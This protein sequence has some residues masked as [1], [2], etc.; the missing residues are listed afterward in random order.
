[1]ERTSPGEE[2]GGAEA[3]TFV[4]NRRCESRVCGMASDEGLK[5]RKLGLERGQ[6]LS[7]GTGLRLLTVVEGLMA[8]STWLPDGRR[9]L[10]CLY[11][12]GDLI[13]PMAGVNAMP[14]Q[15]EALA[16][17]RVCE[18]DLDSR[19]AGDFESDP[20]RA[21]LKAELF[22]AVHRQIMCVSVHLVTLGRLDGMERVCL[23]LADIAWRIG[24]DTP[25]G[26]RFHL[27]LS[28][29][30]IAD[31]LGLNAE[32]VSRIF[33]RIKKSKLATFLSPTE[34]LIHDIAALEGRVP[35][36]APHA[37][38]ASEARFVMEALTCPA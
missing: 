29:E 18:I 38:D 33:S 19:G 28:R 3:W 5:P 17:S 34:L 8:L 2:R 9:Q 12:P 22:S 36:P 32:T 23:F 11:A 4:A 31:Y 35:V 6:S 24:R 25:G 10:L 37:P 1:M 16:P 21:A 26:R 14:M 7:P 27:P 15:I 13:C 20:E 30:D